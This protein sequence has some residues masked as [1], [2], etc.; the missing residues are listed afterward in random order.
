MTSEKTR[1]DMYQ[2]AVD[3]LS[4]IDEDWA[5]LINLVGQCTHRPKPAREPYEALVR[6]VA[7]QQLHARAA[8]AI[9]AKFLGTRE[10]GGRDALLLRGHDVER[11]HREHNDAALHGH[12]N[13]HAIERDAVEQHLHVLDQIYRDAGHADVARDPRM[14]QIVAAMGR[15][16]RTRPT[17]PSG[18]RRDCGGKTRSTPP[19][20]K[21]AYWR[22]VHGCRRYIAGWGP[23][24]YGGSPAA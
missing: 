17:A 16:D 8:D 24:R 19:V 15:L 10:G 3:H 13:G 1:P 20:E 21:P 6:A 12:R 9:I 22:I 14:I 4:Q 23:R 18:R 5:R 11:H 7:Y 2:L